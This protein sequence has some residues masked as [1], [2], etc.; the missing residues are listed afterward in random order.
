MASDLLRPAFPAE[1]QRQFDASLAEFGGLQAAAARATPAVVRTHSDEI[2]QKI[3]AIAP[4]TRWW[5]DLGQL[6]LCINEYL[7]DQVIRARLV[8]YRQRFRE[9][10]GASRF[11]T[12][13][14]A[15]P[16][17]ASAP[18][19]DLRA[20]LA[21]CMRA[22]YYLYAG[23]GIAAKSRNA[24]IKELIAYGSLIVVIEMI[25]A[26]LLGIHQP[27]IGIWWPAIADPTR[28]LLI[29]ATWTSIAAVI[30]S[31]VS[32]QR[33][34][35]DPR[36]DADPYFRYI[37]TSA[38]RLSV[39]FSSPFFGA[40]FGYVIFGLISSKVI[41]SNV[42]SLDVTKMDSLST[43]FVLIL[44]F[45]SGFAEQLVPD[46]LTRVASRALASVSDGGSPS[47][48]GSGAKQPT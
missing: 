5:T 32:V 48:G 42:A 24:L 8:F 47:G 9:V 12:Y 11:A 30:G 1:A 16:I 4:A 34:L 28:K 19:E 14:S 22:V 33:R 2:V 25:V 23:Y 35:E 7:S 40:V 44:G 10:A 45:L 26:F 27:Q 13:L 43:T 21:E 37:Q 46:A 39:S 38:D 41:L 3:A 29:L 17:I 18:I 36:V 20:D 15:A 6:E 31:V